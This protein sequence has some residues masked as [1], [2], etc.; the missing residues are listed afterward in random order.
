MQP[1]VSHTGRVAPLDRVNV[2]TDQIVP[3]QFLKRIE[4]SGY[5]QYLFH[6]WRFMP[7]GRPNPDFVLNEPRYRGASILVTGRNF[8]SGSSR[9]HA[10]WALDDFGIRAVIAPSF[11]DIFYSNCLGNG[12][13]PVQLRDGE[14]QE[15]LM[16]TQQEAGYEVTVDLEECRVDDGAG[17]TA[18][19]SID[20][21]YRHRLLNGLDDIGLTL[22]HEDAIQAYESAHVSYQTRLDVPMFVSRN[23]HRRH[24][25]HISHLIADT[26]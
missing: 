6:D 2:D 10:V 11:A 17:F 22:H 13:L 23:T 20:P 4:R 26:S 3:K 8:G 19:F 14:V 5:G 25:T 16:R 1:F 24:D 7:D 12:L 18:A 9:E 15:L 21:F